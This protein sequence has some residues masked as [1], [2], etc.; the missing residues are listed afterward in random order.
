MVAQYR[1]TEVKDEA[2]LK[3]KDQIAQLEKKSAR[4]I[5]PDFSN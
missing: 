2:L 4:S 3:V 5:I 1:C